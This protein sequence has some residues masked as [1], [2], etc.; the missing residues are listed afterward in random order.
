MYP[1]VDLYESRQALH[2]FSH[3]PRKPW[4]AGERT[5]ERTCTQR[6]ASD[7][8][9]S[10]AS[11]LCNPWN[12]PQW[13]LNGERIASRM[14]T[15]ARSNSTWLGFRGCVKPKAPETQCPRSTSHPKPPGRHIQ[16]APCS[17]RPFPPR[18][19]RPGADG[20]CQARRAR[21]LVRRRPR[22]IFQRRARRPRVTMSMGGGMSRTSEEAQMRARAVRTDH[23]TW[24]RGPRADTPRVHN[25]NVYA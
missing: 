2:S 11:K 20:G 15:F 17:P 5:N 10:D 18:E 12:V 23:G 1:V 13:N 3:K 14:D 19:R 8:T 9:A 21:G 25:Y 24:N 7:R 16:R 4:L 6:S 22:R